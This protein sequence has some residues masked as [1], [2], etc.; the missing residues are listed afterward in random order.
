MS[1]RPS[2]QFYPGDWQRNANLRRCTHAERGAWVDIMCLMHDSETYGVLPW[3]L[4]EIAN[5]INAPLKL[6]Q[7]LVDKGVMKGCDTGMCPAYEF[8][9]K[10]GN[11]KN[12]PV[13]LLAPR[14]GPIWYSSRMI[15]DEYVRNGRAHRGEGR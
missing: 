2:F 1:D 9:P 12:P 3:P 13:T 14:E 7:A 8:I 5:A 11:K 6:V 10:T 4:V 15:K